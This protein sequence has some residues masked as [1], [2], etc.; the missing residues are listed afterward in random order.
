MV[1]FTL[2]DQVQSTGN[3]VGSAF[4]SIAQPAWA[5]TRLHMDFGPDRAAY[6]E[7]N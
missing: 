1:G 4:G 3:S 5:L 6:L 2:F 7:P